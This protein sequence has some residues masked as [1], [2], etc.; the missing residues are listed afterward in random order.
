MYGIQPPNNDSDWDPD[1]CDRMYD[2]ILNPCANMCI[3]PV[4]GRSGPKSNLGIR[5]YDCILVDMDTDQTSTINDKLV[6]SELACYH[7]VDCHQLPVNRNHDANTEIVD[8]D[9]D[10]DTAENW[11]NDN[12]Q[13]FQKPDAA[14]ESQNSADGEIRDFDYNFTEEEIMEV[15]RSLVSHVH[16]NKPQW[17]I[18]FF[19]AA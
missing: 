8:S 13:S 1:L 7:S 18:S 17:L 9:D 12:Y 19:R 10:S 11:D 4:E 14:P 6:S 3:R 2:E 16:S 15:Y 5:S